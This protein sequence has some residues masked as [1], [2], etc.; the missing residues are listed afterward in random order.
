MES[1]LKSTRALSARQAL[2]PGT[3][4][5][6][7]LTLLS[8]K[9]SHGND[10]IHT[11]GFRVVMNAMLK[12]D[13]AIVTIPPGG[14]KSAI[15]KGIENLIW[16]VEDRDSLE[17]AL[18]DIGEDWLLL[19]NLTDV[20]ILTRELWYY[21]G[22]PV[23]ALDTL[24]VA[25]SGPRGRFCTTCPRKCLLMHRP[26]G[27]MGNFGNIWLHDPDF[28]IADAL[29]KLTSECKMLR[30]LVIQ[31]LPALDMSILIEIPENPPRD[32]IKL[33]RVIARNRQVIFLCEPEIGEVLH[34][35]F[36]AFNYRP[37]PNPPADILPIIYERRLQESGLNASPLSSASLSFIAFTSKGNPGKFLRVTSTLLEDMMLE[38]ITETAENQWV[39]DHI[40]LTL[41]DEQALLI[42]L[43]NIAKKTRWTTAAT[44]H[45]E[46]L[47]MGVDLGARSI[48]RRLTD[49]KLRDRRNGPQGTTEYNLNTSAPKE[50]L[51]EL[52]QP[53]E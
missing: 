40:G 4:T 36:P 18:Y 29:G 1:H 9:L 48:G 51:Q 31:G 8:G 10:I 16:G 33:L 17:K 5:S 12:D 13:S 47:K 53:P 52:P 30:Q 14:G 44:V 6:D 42:V 27:T 45:T 19:A 43:A 28:Q 23:P 50:N 26:S 49:L 24:S 21:M 3:F 37:A 35:A 7:D 38:G 34:K 15:I 41:T 2:A 46:L 25:Q 32:F 11:P 22:R 39:R 20:D